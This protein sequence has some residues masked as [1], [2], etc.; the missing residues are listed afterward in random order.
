MGE[1]LACGLVR[2]GVGQFQ[3]QTKVADKRVVGKEIRTCLL[4]GI[5]GV[6]H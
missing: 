1:M 2:R 4:P 5:M 3:V 6:E